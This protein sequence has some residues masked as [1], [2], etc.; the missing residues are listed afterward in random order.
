MGAR[1]AGVAD[2]FGARAWSPGFRSGEVEAGPATLDCG[3][4]RSRSRISDSRVSLE[5]MTTSRCVQGII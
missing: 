1:D 5:H 4:Q 2:D 3:V